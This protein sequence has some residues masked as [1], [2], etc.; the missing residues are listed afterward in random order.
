MSD[1]VE[2]HTIEMMKRLRSEMSNRF[3]RIDNTLIDL[4]T[5]IR[6]HNT[7]ISGLVQQE[8]HTAGKIAELE[9]RLNRIERRL[10]LRDE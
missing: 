3:D 4:L 9:G 1:Q 5:Q 2:N 7:H 6:I 10:E 8:N